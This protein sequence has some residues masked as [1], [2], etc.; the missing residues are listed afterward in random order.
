MSDK[1]KDELVLIDYLTGRCDEQTRLEVI[2]R[3]KTDKDFIALRHDIANT[4]SAMDLAPQPEA[5]ADLADRTMDR[6]FSRIAAAGK[7]NRRELSWRSIRPTFSF[8]ELATVA[9]VILIL[10]AIFIP[11]IR[12]TRRQRNAVLCAS[13]VGQIGSALQTYANSNNGYLPVPYGS[14][15][16]WLPAP[17]EP[18]S[19]NST[20][21]Y[22]LVKLKIAEPV[23]FQCP[24]VGQNSFVVRD[25]TN[26]FPSGKYV[27]YSYQYSLGPGDLAIHNP[28]LKDSA[29]KMVILAD[30]TPIF[31]NGQFQPDRV[32]DTTSGNHNHRG[33]NV[34]YLDMHVDWANTATAGVGD[35]N[36]FLVE[37]VY[38]YKGTEA[39]QDPN[40]TF[41]LPAYSSDTKSDE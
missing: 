7:A 9:S 29:G 6:I 33:Q 27:H 10:S 41:L 25:R 8:R 22:R 12:Q 34:L 30:M 18:V 20:A 16:R 37:G 23:L 32:H 35:D 11:S 5:P 38:D 36:I 26:D 39:P 3:L 2:E 1:N 4:L 13:Q 40:D 28:A 15:P 17:G 21:L 14:S 19:S 31:R 24:S